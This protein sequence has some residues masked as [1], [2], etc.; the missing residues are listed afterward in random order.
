[1]YSIM[2]AVEAAQRRSQQ[3]DAAN[4]VRKPRMIVPEVQPIMPVQPVGGGGSDDSSGPEPDNRTPAEKYRDAVRSNKYAG[5]IPGFGTAIALMNDNYIQNYE[6]Q[7]PGDIL[8]GQRYSTVGRFF[9]FGDPGT[10]GISG[11]FGENSDL[12]DAGL[13]DM[14]G[15]GLGYR[16]DAYRAESG[17]GMGP[18]YSGPGYQSVEA[19]AGTY[20]E[21]DEDGNVSAT[22]F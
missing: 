8:P 21:R 13:F 4:A 6:A 11:V 16:G 18:S 1:M 22:T 20:G 9:G 17:G 12:Y 7:N 10:T 14:V 3:R 5:A 19:A 2:E 15:G